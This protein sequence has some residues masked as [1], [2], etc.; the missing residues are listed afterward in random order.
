MHKL[1]TF[2]QQSSVDL[3]S[4]VRLAEEESQGSRWRALALP[5]QRDEVQYGRWEVVRSK[6]LYPGLDRVCAMDRFLKL[7]L[8]CV[9]VMPG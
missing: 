8:C 1:V 9:H 3:E 2:A 4:E 7:S 6:R 5:D